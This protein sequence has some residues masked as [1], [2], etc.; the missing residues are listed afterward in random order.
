VSTIVGGLC[1]RYGDLEFAEEWVTRDFANMDWWPDTVVLRNELRLRRFEAAPDVDAV[2]NLLQLRGLGLPVTADAF[3]YALNQVD[4]AMRFAS[5]DESKRNELSLVQQRLL[6]AA[7]FW[8]HGSLFASFAGPSTM[9]APIL[10]LAEA[11]A[12]AAQGALV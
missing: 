1:L 9:I 10:G 5:L 11:D 6:R 3:V 2:E 4:D 12:P 7:R 8:Q